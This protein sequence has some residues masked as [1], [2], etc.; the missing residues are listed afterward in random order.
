MPYRDQPFAPLPPPLVGAGRYS[1]LLI[2][3]VYLVCAAAF[4]SDLTRANTLAYGIVYIPLITTA[5]FHE[6]RSGLWLLTGLAC[7]LVLIGAFA[8]TVDPDLPDLIGNRILSILAILATAAFVHHARMTQDRL[9]DQA[10]RIEAAERVKNEVFTNLSQE[11]RTPLRSLLGLLSLMMASCRPDQLEALGRVR[12]GG[13]QLLDTIENMIDLT[14]ID[15]RT[16]RAQDVDLAA[17][18]Q[19]AAD[20]AR[21]AADER[22]VAIEVPPP[23]Q[24]PVVIADPWAVR[25]I[26]DNLIANAIR[27]SQPG[28]RVSVVI[29]REAGVVTASVSDTGVGMP[30]DVTRY[31]ADALD[32]TALPA[33]G[34]AGL[35][36]SERL[37]LAMNGRL[38]VG[39][40]AGFGATVSLSLPAAGSES[41]GA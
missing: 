7:L 33:T 41:G 34:G 1:R 24:P 22:A 9:A 8:P 16:F 3:A 5:L 26:L 39:S 38:S 25:R 35:T 12:T 18:L 6:R 4:V 13:K 17:V 15:E 30:P 19:E 20:T 10:R 32:N 27:F 14:Q 11:M 23:N 2:T 31:F 28:G 36:L 37:A 29:G 21:G 40:R